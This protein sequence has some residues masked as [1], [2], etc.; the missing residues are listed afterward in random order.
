MRLR[1]SIGLALA[2]VIAFAG[3]GSDGDD[4]SGGSGNEVTVEM[5]AFEYGFRADE[6]LEIRAGDRVTFVV[7]ND[8]EIDHLLEVLT[9]ASRS[10]GRTERIPPGAK[11]ELTVDFEEAGT[12]RVICDIDDHLT[13]GQQAVFDVTG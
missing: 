13:R 5:S 2:G 11:R 7:R 9:D 6:A 12:Y 8:G 3:C 1:T 4:G 10:L